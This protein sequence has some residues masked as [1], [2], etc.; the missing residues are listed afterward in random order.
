MYQFTSGCPFKVDHTLMNYVYNVMLWH[1]LKKVRGFSGDFTTRVSMT[2]DWALSSEGSFT[3]TLA[4]PLRPE[5][6]AHT[7]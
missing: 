2:D 5:T 4:F 7:P 1:H 6:A 3:L